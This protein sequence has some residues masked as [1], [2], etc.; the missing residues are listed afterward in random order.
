MNVNE[1]N[2]NYYLFF[3]GKIIILGV[4][5][6]WWF[7]FNINGWKIYFC[8]WRIRVELK[9]Y[10]KDIIKKSTSDRLWF[11]F[12]FFIFMLLGF[13]RFGTPFLMLVRTIFITGGAFLIGRAML[14][15]MPIIWRAWILI[16]MFIGRML[17][18]ATT[19]ATMMFIFRGR[20]MAF[21]GTTSTK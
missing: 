14:T 18:F 1:N 4:R 8:K 16:F 10:F 12:L 6:V 13:F 15:T 21:A 2:A 11:N 5:I 9:Y 7:L 20:R 19:T 17:V 3:I